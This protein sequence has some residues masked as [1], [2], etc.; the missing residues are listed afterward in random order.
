M[1]DIVFATIIGYFK[2]AMV[3]AFFK[4]VYTLLLVDAAVLL[5]FFRLR[6]HRSS[7]LLQSP[8]RILSCYSLRI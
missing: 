1:F 3:S 7:Q 2:F 8:S 4:T 5:V 6:I